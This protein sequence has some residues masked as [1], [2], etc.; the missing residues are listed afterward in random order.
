MNF[1]K[2]YFMRGMRQDVYGINLIVLVASALIFWMLSAYIL[3]KVI[4]LL[5]GVKLNVSG[6]K[7]ASWFYK[8]KK[9]SLIKL[10]IQ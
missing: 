3:N 10:F 8:T 1:N 4:Y 6:Y 5:K 9:K 2:C 7:L